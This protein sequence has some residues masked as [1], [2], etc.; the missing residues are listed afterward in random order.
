MEETTWVATPFRYRRLRRN[1]SRAAVVLGFAIRGWLVLAGSASPGTTPPPAPVPASLSGCVGSIAGAV[2]VQLTPV[3]G[4]VVAPVVPVVAAP[5]VD[6]V[7]PVGPQVAAMVAPAVQTLSAVLAPVDTILAPLTPALSPVLTPVTDPLASGLTTDGPCVAVEGLL[8]AVVHSSPARTL[9]G[10]GVDAGPLAGRLPAHAA[11]PG[12]GTTLGD[13]VSGNSP[14]AAPTTGTDPDRLAAPSDG[15]AADGGSDPVSPSGGLCSGVPT[16]CPSGVGQ[17][18]GT[19]TDAA[20]LPVLTV[21]SFAWPATNA[22]VLTLAPA[23]S[24]RHPAQRLT[25]LVCR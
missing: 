3:I 25:G 11:P 8:T 18:L 24:P 6:V 16:S 21:S 17:L 1:G 14:S 4:Q 20:A 15:P 22:F 13:P 10:T 7:A 12:R 9:A 19:A 5:A 23:L 2:S